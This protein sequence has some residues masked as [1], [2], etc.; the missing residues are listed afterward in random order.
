MSLLAVEDLEDAV[1]SFVD[2]LDPR[3][4]RLQELAAILAC[5]DLRYLPEKYRTLDRAEL[6]TEFDALRRVVR[7]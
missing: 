1:S 3:L 2:P 5:S 6:S 7:S 4:L